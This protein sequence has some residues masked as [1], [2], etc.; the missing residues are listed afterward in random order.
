MLAHRLRFGLWTLALAA[1]GAC[2][3]PTVVYSDE[4]AAAQVG[5]G[6]AG[7]GCSVTGSC[8]ANATAC[9]LE[10]AEK[11]MSCREKCPNE[12][13]DTCLSGCETMFNAKLGQCTTACQSCAKQQCSDAAASCQELVGGA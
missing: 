6:E 11:R 3:F 5:G 2:S 7:S 1:L 9:G 13:G 10:A 8:A 4:D 12:P